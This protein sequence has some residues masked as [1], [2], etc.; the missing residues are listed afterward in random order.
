LASYF[1]YSGVIVLYLNSVICSYS[2]K[3][4]KEYIE[5]AKPL[6]S[7]GEYWDT[8]N[9]NG[10]TLD[11]NQGILLK[12]LIHQINE[13]FLVTKYVNALAFQYFFFILHS[14]HLFFTLCR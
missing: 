5:G 13:Y 6:L 8:C 12:I 11:Y 7:V 9:Y 3:Y 2:P 1:I 4:V 14:A 10:S